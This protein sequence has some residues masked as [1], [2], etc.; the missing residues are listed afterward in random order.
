MKKIILFFISISI[1]HLMYAQEINKDTVDKIH[2]SVISIDTHN[3]SEKYL[4]SSQG[5]GGGSS[6]KKHQVTFK[7]MKEGGL[8]AAFFACFLSQKSND[9]RS[10]DSV[11]NY[12]K[13]EIKS[14]IKYVNNHSDEAEI[15]YCPK[16]LERIKKSGKSAVVLAI[17]N[18][19]GISDDVNHIDEFFDMGVRSITLCHNLNNLICDASMEKNTNTNSGGLT[20]FGKKVVARM[21]ELG[22][23][24]DVSHAASSTLMDVLKC[25]KSPIIATHSGVWAIKNHNR[26]LKDE[27]IKAIASKGGL[28]QVATGRFFLST[29]PKNQVNIKTLVNHIDYVK[30]LVGIEH[31]GIGTDFDGGGGVVGLED[32]SKMKLITEEMLRRGYTQEELRLFWGGNVMRVWQRILDNASDK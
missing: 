19:Y 9:K 11:Y 14:F 17:E 16:D 15:A 26:N 3:D 12:C 32:C 22:M 21:N 24:I 2:R 4:L 28:I 30:N 8:D 23:I 20:P 5:E 13:K 31:V 10:L 1:Y 6:G 18:G 7:K 25:S 27:E 29:L